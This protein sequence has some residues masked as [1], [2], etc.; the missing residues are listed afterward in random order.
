MS[1]NKSEP[2]R[3]GNAS[4][5]LTTRP[6]LSR[7]AALINYCIPLPYASSRNLH[8]AEMAVC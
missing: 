4:R 2:S 8:I 7:S 6:S 5:P 3:A 1:A